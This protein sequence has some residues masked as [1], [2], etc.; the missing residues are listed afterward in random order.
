M[1]TLMSGSSG[2]ACLHK[3]A[4]V[5]A[6]AAHSNLRN[7]FR[8]SLIASRHGTPGLGTLRPR[9]DALRRAWVNALHKPDACARR[10]M[11]SAYAGILRLLPALLLTLAA[12]ARAQ[13]LDAP[14]REDQLKAGYVVNFAKFVEWPES[15][16]AGALTICIAG[17]KGVYEALRAGNSSKLVGTRRIATREVLTVES[18]SGCDVLYIE[19][20]SSLQMRQLRTNMATLTVSNSKGFAHDGGTIELFTEQNRLRFIVNLE[21]ARRAGLRISSRLLQLAAVVEG[22]DAK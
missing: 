12:T 11:I 7:S 19:P 9:W 1:Y 17:N 2:N 16:P 14:T 15:T 22:G 21:N 4:T 6:A 18:I 13:D 10:G 20:M 3:V 5:L 8:I